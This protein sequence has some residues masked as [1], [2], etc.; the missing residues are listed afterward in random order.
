MRWI[1]GSPGKGKSMMEGE[2]GGGGDAG[3]LGIQ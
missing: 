2:K 1:I 3:L